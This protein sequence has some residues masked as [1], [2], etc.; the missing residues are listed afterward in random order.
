M[1]QRYLFRPLLLVVVFLFLSCKKSVNCDNTKLTFVNMTN[2]SIYY[3]WGCNSYRDTLLPGA[4]TTYDVGPIN[5]RS[6]IWSTSSSIK[7]VP[8]NSTHGS[9]MVKVDECYIELPLK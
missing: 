9:Y 5:V 7:W 1:S 8:F 3:C 2:E 4:K 6:S